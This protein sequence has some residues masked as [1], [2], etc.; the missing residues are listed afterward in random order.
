[1]GGGGGRHFG[2]WGFTT[3]IVVLFLRSLLVVGMLVDWAHRDGRMADAKIAGG[4]APP[5]G[6]TIRRPMR[7]SWPIIAS[8]ATTL[9]V[10][11]PLLFWTGVVG[12]FMKYLPITVIL[13]LSASLFM[14]LIFIPVMGGVIGRRQPQSAHAKAALHAAEVGDP[15]DTRRVHRRLCEAPAM[16]DSQPLDDGAFWPLSLLLGSLRA[17]MANSDAA[18]PSFPRWSPKFMQVEVRARGQSVDL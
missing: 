12:E 13:T 9:S 15:R 17:S 18:S 5:P 4:N 8:T 6:P 2:R 16:V 10:F 3:Y 11:L 1:M 7:M 14:A